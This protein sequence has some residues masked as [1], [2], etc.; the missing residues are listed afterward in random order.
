MR[1]CMLSR[2]SCV[3]SCVTP[4]S[5]G[6]QASLS[7]G[8]LQARILEWAAMPPSRGSSQPSDQTLLFY[9]LLHWQ[10][11]LTSATWDAHYVY[12]S[13]FIF[14]KEGPKL[15]PDFLRS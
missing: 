9:C 2:F 3:C 1:V 12:L 7:M 14:L 8:I 13:M 5:T 11:V 4:R 10:A 6:H 15:S